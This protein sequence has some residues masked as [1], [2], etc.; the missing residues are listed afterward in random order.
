VLHELCRN[1][2]IFELLQRPL[3]ERPGL[4]PHSQ[5]LIE[6]GAHHQEFN[7]RW[8]E[9]IVKRYLKKPVGSGAW[10]KIQIACVA[11]NMKAFERITVDPNIMTGRPCIRG[12]R[13]T[14]ATI[15][16]LLAAG[17]SRDEI[18]RNY[19][20]L[21]EADLEASLAYAAWRM[22]EYEAPLIPAA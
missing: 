2:L 7:I 20:F 5:F 1:S 11:K 17:A 22:E 12:M 8:P 6:N 14:V 18:L 15:I 21:E 3:H 4:I 10:D 13:V 19:P 16:G 9:G